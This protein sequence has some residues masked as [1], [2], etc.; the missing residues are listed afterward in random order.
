MAIECGPRGVVTRFSR[1]AALVVTAFTIQS[2]Y[3]TA[4]VGAAAD[5]VPTFRSKSHVVLIDVLVTDRDGS[6]V[7]GLKRDD[8]TLNDDGAAQTISGFEEHQREKSGEQSAQIVVEPNSY[9]NWI[10][11]PSKGAA[12]IIVFDVLNTGA[13]GRL[14]GRQQM[15]KFLKQIPPGERVALFM[16]DT[17]LRMVQDFTSDPDVLV[18]AASKIRMGSGPQPDAVAL[19]GDVHVDTMSMRVAYTLDAIR[20][21]GR[22]T[23][24]LPGRKNVIWLTTGFPIA[25][26]PGA[27]NS[28]LGDIKVVNQQRDFTGDVRKVATTLAAMQI[29]I[30]PVDLNGL[31]A[32]TLGSDQHKSFN[33]RD[34]RDTM[35]ALAQETGGRA[36]LNKN[37]LNTGIA[38]VLTTDSNYY[39]LAYTPRNIKWN[40][41]YHTVSVKLRRKNVQLTYRRGYHAT[42][43]SPIT[44]QQASRILGEVLDNGAL[45]SR[46]IVI[47]AKV[48]QPEA[49][50]QPLRMTVNIDPST[51]VFDDMADGRNS[52]ALAIAAAAWDAENHKV[53][54]IA[55]KMEPLFEP[56]Q[57]A[58]ARMTGI[59]WTLEMK[60]KPGAYTLKL[61]V[62]D[63]KSG[64]AGSL[65]V[66]LKVR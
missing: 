30:Y 3:N 12:N 66:P 44:Q 19:A 65:T 64:K 61:A 6:P 4:A 55:R 9:T 38:R 60:L 16:L 48:S 35:L 50:G 17:R 58:S 8:F 43:D 39:T 49:P 5:P 20:D 63:L 31:E 27:T 34:E 57:L 37:D 1:I 7:R 47:A 11:L 15:L 25:V 23:A 32:K 54:D 21:L 53:S 10:A 46:M 52:A 41:S 26:R 56:Q 13:S 24:S 18:A 33:G 62:V 2:T 51:L 14:Y 42:G 40:G 45:D 36:Y 59:P 29:A 22:V 28:P